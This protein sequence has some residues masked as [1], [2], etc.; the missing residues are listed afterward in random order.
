MSGPLDQLIQRADSEAYQRGYEE[1][2]K[3]EWEHLLKDIEIMRGESI[4]SDSKSAKIRER[5]YHDGSLMV[6]DRMANYLIKR[7]ERESLRSKERE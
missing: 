4:L 3:A 7:S 5:V 1:G 6:Y 2:A